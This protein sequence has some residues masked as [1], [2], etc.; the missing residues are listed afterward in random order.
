MERQSSLNSTYRFSLF[1]WKLKSYSRASGLSRC[2]NKSQFP[3]EVFF[4]AAYSLGLDCNE[5]QQPST[6]VCVLLAY[7]HILR[8][9]IVSVTLIR[10][11]NRER[12]IIIRCRKPNNSSSSI[13]N[14]KRRDFLTII[15]RDKSW[16]RR[17][18]PVYLSR[19]IFMNVTTC[20]RIS[21]E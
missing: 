7:T 13:D 4:S 6:A 9:S 8:A 3:W 1:C 12:I 16:N 15:D 20:K 5:T 21:T 2:Y 18:S 17:Y 11:F 10:E 14:Q 19:P